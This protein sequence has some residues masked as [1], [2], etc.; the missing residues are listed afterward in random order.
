MATTPRRTTDDAPGGKTLP[1]SAAS[2]LLLAALLTGCTTA[3]VRPS[4]GG[5]GEGVNVPT[6][7]GG[8]GTQAARLASRFLGTPYRFGGESPDD[9]FDC[10]G[11]V[12]YVYRE[13]GVP[14]PRTAA[15]QRANARPVRREDLQPGDLVF[16]YTPQD[17]V[18]I[19]LGDGHFVH[20][21]AT[22]RTVERARLDTPYFILSFAGAGRFAR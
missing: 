9:G 11:L 5:G 19:Y 4:G 12:W 14:V 2:L 16:F 7:E 17:H 6:E 3:P 8:A 10:S 15:D 18:G 1:P 13:L 21:P 22:G 20:A